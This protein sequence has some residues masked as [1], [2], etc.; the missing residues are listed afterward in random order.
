M[1]SFS[2]SFHWISLGA[3]LSDELS[4]PGISLFV[5]PRYRGNQNNPSRGTWST[6]V[7]AFREILQTLQLQN[8]PVY[9]SW[10]ICNG[11]LRYLFPVQDSS[12]SLALIWSKM[13][14]FRKLFV[15]IKF[16]FKFTKDKWVNFWHVFC[17]AVS[18]LLPLLLSMRKVMMIS[19]M[20]MM[21]TM[22][23]DKILTGI[24]RSLFIFQY[25]HRGTSKKAK[26]KAGKKYFLNWPIA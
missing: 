4:N 26:L 1:S 8:L 22:M 13:V 19:M 20:R 25:H 24:T 10:T 9:F 11:I 2:L 6:F 17:R 18:I 23:T 14:L 7:S 3:T 12:A 21:T 5:F 16:K 15:N